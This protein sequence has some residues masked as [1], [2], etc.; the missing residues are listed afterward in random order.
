MQLFFALAFAAEQAK[1]C[2]YYVYVFH[3]VYGFMLRQRMVV[4]VMDGLFFG[5]DN[6]KKWDTEQIT[7]IWLKVNDLWDFGDLSECQLKPGKSQLEP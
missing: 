3:G 6:T 4:Y 5:K 1:G 7:E 2:Y